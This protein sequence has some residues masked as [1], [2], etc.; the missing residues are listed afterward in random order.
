MLFRSALASFSTPNAQT[1]SNK[2]DPLA[3]AAATSGTGQVRVIAQ[4]S[5]LTA[6]T[7]LVSALPLVGGVAHRTLGIINAVV[8][9]LP[10]SSLN[11][12][13]LNPLVTHISL[14]RST[15]GAMER[16]GATVGATDVRRDYGYEGT[17]VGVAVI[18]SGITGTHDDL[19]GAQRKI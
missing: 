19:S 14:D 3:L 16:T 8:I 6:T 4:T 10:A 12:L 5:S 17:V 7:Q 11:A 13:A 15:A 2:F 9:T 1:T 18:D